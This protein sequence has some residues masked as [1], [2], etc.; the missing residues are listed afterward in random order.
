M[1]VLQMTN[2]TI[3]KSARRCSSLARGR[4]LA[5]VVTI[6][7]SATG[8]AHLFS[9]AADGAAAP[10]EN[11]ALIIAG[12]G[13]E[14]SFTKK[15]FEQSS[16]LYALLT[17]DFHYDASKVTYLF[18]EPGY[19]SL[20]ID[21]I[22]DAAT[23]RRVFGKLRR[24]MKT[25]DQLLVFLIGHGSF[26]GEWAKFNLAGPDL[27]DLDYAQMLSSLPTR[28]VIF[29][30]TA[31]ASGAFVK[32]LSAAERVIVTA[33][34]SGS[35]N[36][37]TNFADFLLDALSAGAADLNKD[38]RISV[39]EAFTF[40]RTSQDRWFEEQRRLRAQ[41]PLLDDNADGAGSQRLEEG[42]DGSLARG[43]FL[44]G[45]SEEVRAALA[46]AA[47]ADAGPRE[48]LLARKLQL[49]QQIA[50]LKARKS[51][52]PASDYSKQL[53]ALLIPLART[54]KQLRALQ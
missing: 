36:Y 5:V 32:N 8:P 1:Q 42:A 14:E 43:V 47:S 4:C 38:K 34:K 16:R 20:T 6:L 53:E 21:G 22:P 41:H 11:Y 44:D 45:S 40:A 25:G 23:I 37:E 9:Q 18:A 7:F 24:E 52:M 27:R 17:G 29:I 33:T 46:R 12:P 13:G 19:D 51:Q 49:E 3:S 2:A 10:P 15:Y 39:A 50:A 31:S 26:D 48:K 35:E 30:N 54:G 28:N